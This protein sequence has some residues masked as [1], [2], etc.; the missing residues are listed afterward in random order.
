M[1]LSTLEREIFNELKSVT[2]NPKL[3]KRDF[4]QWS[5]APISPPPGETCVFLPTLKLYATYLT[6]ISSGPKTT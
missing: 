2:N 5:T 6:P 1:T 3:L 4:A